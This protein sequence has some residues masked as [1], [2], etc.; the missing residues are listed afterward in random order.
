MHFAT[1]LAAATFSTV[2]ATYIGSRFDHSIRVP[3]KQTD[4]LD[5]QAPGNSYNNPQKGQ[6]AHDG[7]SAINAGNNTNVTS[8]ASILHPGYLIGV[9]IVGLL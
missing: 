4:G 6:L 2:S 3:M 7:G 9:V 1:L 8:G 5:L